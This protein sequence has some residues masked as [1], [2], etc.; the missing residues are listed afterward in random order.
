MSMR[1]EEANLH[2]FKRNFDEEME[3]LRRNFSEAGQRIKPGLK[4]TAKRTGDALSDIVN[5]IVKVIGIFVIIAS[6]IILIAAIIALLSFLGG[7]D[8]SFLIENIQPTHFIDPAYYTLFVW[9]V[10]LTVFIPVLSLIMLSIRIITGS[11]I[12]KYFGYS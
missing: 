12:N 3:G 10:F 8:N 4:N 5:I 11:K 7:S 6:I 9:L 2:N 1:G